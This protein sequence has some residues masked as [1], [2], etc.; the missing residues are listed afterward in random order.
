MALRENPRKVALTSAKQSRSFPMIRRVFA[1]I[2][3][4]ILFGVLT[5]ILFTLLIGVPDSV[6]GF[7]WLAVVGAASGAFLGASFPRVFGFFFEVVM[8]IIEE[9]RA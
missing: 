3:G 7:V 9:F 4:A 8:R 5:P 6:I 1:G 2:F